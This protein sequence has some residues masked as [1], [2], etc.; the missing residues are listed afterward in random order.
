MNFKVD[1]KY[2][3]ALVA[4]LAG[5]A[6]PIWIWQSDLNSRAIKLEV[7][8]VVELDPKGPKPID[9]L[10][11]IFKDT[12]IKEAYLTVL[13][14]SNTGNRPILASEFESAVAINLKAPINLLKAEVIFVSPKDLK[15]EVVI[16]EN[17]AQ[18]KPLLLNPNDRLRISI[19]SS[20][21]WPVVEARS[22]IAGIKNLTIEDSAFILPRSYYWTRIALCS[23]LL[24]GYMYMALWTF[25]IFNKSKRVPYLLVAGVLAN[26]FAVVILT[27]PL[28]LESPYWDLYALT[29]LSSIAALQ[30][31]FVK[32]KAMQFNI[33]V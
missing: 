7:I 26:G 23:A 13:Q 16:S 20:N 17:S 2:S 15:P 10:K 11:L 22:R 19:L 14:I 18:L 33:N 24:F 32:R 27:R 5:V 1:W 12:Q 28:R 31:F 3:I 30:T 29:T 4:A 9:D 25:E 21:G 6:V 8:A